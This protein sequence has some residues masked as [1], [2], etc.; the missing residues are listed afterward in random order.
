MTPV[1]R[2]LVFA[3]DID[4]LAIDHTVRRREDY[5]VVRSPSNPAFWYGNFLLFDGPP[6]AGDGELGA[7]VRARVRRRAADPPPHVRLGSHRRRGRRRR[8]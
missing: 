5:L 2:S 7:A 3:T 8:Q 4:V 1:Q 6:T